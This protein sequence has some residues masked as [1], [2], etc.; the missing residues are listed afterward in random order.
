[1]LQADDEAID[2][3]EAVVKDGH[4][5][6]VRQRLAASRGHDCVVDKKGNTSWSGWLE[7]KGVAEEELRSKERGSRE[8][9][10]L[11]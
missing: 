3:V 5:A 6:L 1:M 4:V 8:K 10:A 11:H 7:G 9:K 2:V